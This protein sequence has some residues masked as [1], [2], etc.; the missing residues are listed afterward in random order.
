MLIIAGENV[1]PREIEEVINHHPTV[2]EA[3]VVGLTDPSR[4][5][6]PIAFVELREGADWDEADVRSFVRQALPPYKVPREF[7]V[8]EALPRNPTG[9]VLRRALAEKLRAEGGGAGA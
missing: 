7:R 3:A 4:G 1:F 6:V 2:K 8:L 9:K 5:E